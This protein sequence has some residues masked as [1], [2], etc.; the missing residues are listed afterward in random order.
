[1]EKKK[2]NKKAE[3]PKKGMI[4]KHIK[5]KMEGMDF[6]MQDFEAP[7][8]EEAKALFPDLTQ[9]EY[10]SERRYSF[11]ECYRFLEILTFWMMNNSEAVF[12]QDFYY[13]ALPRAVA[14][15]VVAPI[16]F[17]IN[18]DCLVNIKKFHPYFD[19]M[20]KVIKDV[21]D[22]RIFKKGLTGEWYSGLVGFWLKTHSKQDW[23]EVQKVETVNKTQILNIDPLE[24]EDE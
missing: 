20:I 2:R 3:T 23:T 4:A 10:E 21:Q 7:S 13:N 8:F 9:E 6:E 5:K 1:M 22:Y 24:K 17:M 14:N 12:F 15:G 19:D 16:K 18:K 11:K